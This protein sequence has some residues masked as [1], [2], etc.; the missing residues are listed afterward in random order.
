MRWASP[1]TTAVLPTPGSPMR[2]G[3]FFVRRDRTWTTRR[4]SLSR[5]MTGSS[6][7]SRATSVRSRPYFDRASK[8]PSG[9]AEVIGSGRSWARAALSASAVAPPWVRMRPASVSEAASAMSRC[10]VETYWSPDFSARR[11][12]SWTAASSAREAWAEPADAP[13][14]L[15]RATRAL[16]VRAPIARASAPTASSRDR[17]MPSRCSMRA[18]SRWMGSTCGFPAAEADWSAEATASC[19][20]VVISRAM[21]SFLQMVHTCRADRSRRLW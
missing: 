13:W 5:P 11:S 21:R 9:S 19:A 10:S 6:L 15:G 2:T 14:A 20:F 7:P 3:L 4:I 17:A 18:C 1:S 12:A 16:R 8:E